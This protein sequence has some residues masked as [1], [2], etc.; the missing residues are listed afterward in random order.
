MLAAAGEA[1]STAMS[2]EVS[3]RIDPLLFESG[4]EPF[5]APARPAGP[6][7]AP[8]LAGARARG[9]ADGLEWLGL[10]AVLLD[11]RGEALHANAGAIELMGEGLFLQAG[12]LRA[13]DPASD[14]ALGEAVRAAVTQSVATR[15]AVASRV[16]DAA[17]FVR[18]AAIDSMDDDPFQ[19][20]R[21]VVILEREGDESARRRH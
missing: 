14:A 21:V 8:L 9:V 17:L 16:G 11:D 2:Q 6:P 19:L 3:M 13:R 7:L 10:A 5:G 18:V 12:R 20:L 15:L 1:R 4:P